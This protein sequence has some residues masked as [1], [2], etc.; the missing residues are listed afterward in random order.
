VNPNYGTWEYDDLDPVG[1][2]DNGEPYVR[3]TWNVA[4]GEATSDKPV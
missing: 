2:N 3:P 1:W 4:D